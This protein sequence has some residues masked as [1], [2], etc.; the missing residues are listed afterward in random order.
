MLRWPLQLP[1]ATNRFLLYF[2]LLTFCSL[3][4]SREISQCVLYFVRSHGRNLRNVIVVG[5][6][7]DATALAGRITKD[8][9]LGYRVLQIIEAKDGENGKFTTGIRT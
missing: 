9:S 3:A 4:L 7:L 6:G 8:V 1:F 2:W 5:E